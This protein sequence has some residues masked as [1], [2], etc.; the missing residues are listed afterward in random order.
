[1]NKAKSILTNIKVFA[2]YEKY[3]IRGEKVKKYYI[4][5]KEFI[6]S[7][8][9]ISEN[10]VVL[11]GDFDGVHQGHQE[12]LERAKIKAKEQKAEIA[13]ITFKHHNSYKIMNEQEKLTFFEATGIKYYIC[14]LMQPEFRK[15]SPENFL[16]YLFN[17]FM[18]KGIVIGHDFKFG[19]RQ[20]GNIEML[21]KAK[22]KYNYTLT[23]VEMIKN[24]NGE[25]ISSSRIRNS[26]ENGQVGLANQLLG[27]PFK[28]LGK[29]IYGKQIG[30]TLGFP[31]ANIM[32]EENKVIPSNGVYLV[33]INIDNKKYNAVTNIGRAP[34]IKNEQQIIIETHI[35]DF[36]SNIYDK[37][38]IITF[39]K[40]IRNEEKFMSVED[41][42]ELIKDD[43]AMA[44]TFFELA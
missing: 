6:K 25:R 27:H 21:E 5:Y 7:E 3:A 36:S 17:N 35:L 39:L 15:L 44:R 11:I 31:T 30:R 24:A 19:Y 32:P 43:I 26:I 29:V 34:T 9:K 12:L 22:N 28:I 14:F 38:I 42:Q 40:K 1:M 10:L 13:V 20:R 8:R 33:E 37:E 16:K 2:Y 41:L 4:T 23:I 18:I